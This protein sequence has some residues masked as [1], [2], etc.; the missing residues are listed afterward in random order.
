MAI[1]R[2]ANGKPKVYFI[3]PDKNDARHIYQIFQNVIVGFLSTRP[4]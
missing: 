4:F 2:F 1:M 3:A